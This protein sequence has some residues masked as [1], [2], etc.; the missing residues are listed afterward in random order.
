MAGNY[1]KKTPG[2]RNWTLHMEFRLQLEQI[3]ICRPAGQSPQSGFGDQLVAM[4]P[5]TI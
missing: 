5:Q 3:L 4:L 1:S 2:A